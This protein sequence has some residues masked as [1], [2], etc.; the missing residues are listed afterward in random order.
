MIN[1]NEPASKVVAHLLRF[2]E[3][4]KLSDLEKATAADLY[5]MAVGVAK[6]IDRLYPS[7]D[8][9]MNLREVAKLIGIDP[10]DVPRQVEERGLPCPIIQAPTRNVMKFSRREVHAWWEACVSGGG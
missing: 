1:A 7:T 10:K 8:S 9:I 5:E 4:L 6:S 2:A 3:Q